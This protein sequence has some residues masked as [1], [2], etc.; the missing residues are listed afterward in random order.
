MLVLPLNKVS[1]KK[2]LCSNI[3]LGRSCKHELRYEGMKVNMII[4]LNSQP[5]RL[6]NNL[7][8]FAALSQKVRGNITLLGKI[9]CGFK[10]IISTMF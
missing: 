10:L 4:A 5:I 3:K 2:A 9:L 6:K 7:K 1:I 8:N